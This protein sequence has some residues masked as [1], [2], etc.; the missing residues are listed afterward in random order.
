MSN[1]ERATSNLPALRGPALDI[2]AEDVTL[3]RLAVGQFMSNVVQE[4]LVKAGSLYLHLGA[5]DADPN[6]VYD[7]K[8]GGEGVLI[9]VL[10]M[11]K[12]KSL[13][14][15]GQLLRYAANDPDAP[16]EA[17]TT[18]DYF[19]A[20]PE[21]DETIPGKFLLTRASAPAAKQMNLVLA[22]GQQAGKSAHELAFRVSTLARENAKGKYFVVRVKPVEATQENVAIAQSMVDMIGGTAVEQTSTAAADAPAI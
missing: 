4:G 7:P 22:K 3:P 8:V 15:D 17:W 1:I 21:V 10:G 6:V 5:D 16:A 20:L 13:V 11:R 19:V 14:V 9:H 2:S 12:G 18:Y